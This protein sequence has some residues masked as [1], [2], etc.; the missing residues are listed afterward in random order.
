MSE[1]RVGQHTGMPAMA[2]IKLTLWAARRSRLG[3]LTFGSP[4][5][6]KA[7]ARHWSAITKRTFGLEEE[8]AAEAAAS[9]SASPQL[10]RN[11]SDAIGFA[12]RFTS[13]IDGPSRLTTESD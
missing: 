10:S 12:L 5:Y 8:A 13:S 3:V 11:I 4:A 7:E 1:A 9:Q 6:P 2:L